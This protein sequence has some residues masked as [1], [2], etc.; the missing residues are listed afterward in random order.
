MVGLRSKYAP[1]LPATP[2]TQRRSRGRTR[3]RG[4]RRVSVV[5][6]LTES[7]DQH[8][9][10]IR[11][12][13]DPLRKNVHVRVDGLPLPGRRLAGR[14]AEMEEAE[15]ALAC[16]DADD[17]P[18]ARGPKEGGRPPV[19]GEAPLRRGEEHEC[20]RGRGRADVLFVLDELAAQDGGGDDERRR[21]LELRRFARAAAFLQR[22][23]GL[24]A[25][26]A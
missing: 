7:R 23:K 6:M 18:A 13:P 12:R 24:R 22:G 20:D 11:E 4:S 16:S 14:S 26:D 1:R 8:R 3:R 21:A 2:P 15:N 5:S 25:D 9:T 17:L 19:R 10:A